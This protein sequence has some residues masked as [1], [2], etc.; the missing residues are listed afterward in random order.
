MRLAEVA[1]HDSIDQVIQRTLDE[2][3]GLTASSIAFFH[4]LEADQQTITLQTWSTNTLSGICTAQG[5]GTHYPIAQAGVWAD[6]VRVRQAVVHNDYPA[7]AQRRGLP[8]GHV[9]VQREV[10][11]PVLR[12]E[13]VVA[14]MGVGNATRPYDAED[15]EV[16]KTL[17]DFAYDAVERRRT[18][19]A[20]ARSE[21]RLRLAMEATSDGL[22]DWDAHHAAGVVEPADVPDA[23][24]RSRAGSRGDVGPGPGSPR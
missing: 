14:I 21:E 11:V 9:P 2:A 8:D 23:R 20:L 15:V 18:L 12:A 4:F 5:K 16:L 24:V 3:E 1:V 17:A 22:W 19:D 6:C 10:V 13:I 7:L